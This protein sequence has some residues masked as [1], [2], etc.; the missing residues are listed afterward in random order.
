MID[1]IKEEESW[2]IRCKMIV[3]FHN[4]MK[5][6]RNS[7]KRKVKWRLSD[8]AVALDISIGLVSES[9]KLNKLLQST[10][11]LAK[12]NREEVLKMIRS[13]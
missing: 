10:P 3:H 1:K 7:N 4:L 12:L 2:S 8:T 11:D 6:R 9:I 13:S 5:K